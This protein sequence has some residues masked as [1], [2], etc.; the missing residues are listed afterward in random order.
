MS[1]RAAGTSGV[2]VT[3]GAQQASIT[4]AGPQ[5]E[6]LSLDQVNV[7]IPPSLAGKGDVVVQLSAN[8]ISANPV[9][10]TIR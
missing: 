10:I 7:V 4:Y 3:V 8:G 1:L 5:E 9:H 2:Q 6:F